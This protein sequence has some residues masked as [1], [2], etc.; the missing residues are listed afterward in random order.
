MQIIQTKKIEPIE[1]NSI[2]SDEFKI[3]R[4]RQNIHKGE[5][6]IPPFFVYINEYAWDAFIK[7]GNNVYD[8]TQ[9]EAQGILVGK[10]FKDTFGTFIVATTY[11]E[12]VGYSNSAFVSMTEECLIDIG[13]KCKESDDIMLIWVHTHPD[14]GVF[15]SGTDKTCLKNNF[16]KPYQIGIV[17][18]IIRKQHRGFKIINNEVED[19]GNYSLYNDNSDRL[20]KPYSLNSI[21]LTPINKIISNENDLTQKKNQNST[22][23]NE[24][25][26]NQTE[27]TEEKKETKKDDSNNDHINKSVSIILTNSLLI[28]TI[29][30][31]VLFIITMIFLLFYFNK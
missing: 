20:M 16:Y 9:F 30:V 2:S 21:S 25:T 13:K 4:D 23:H 22:I 5:H 15:Y 14:F 7:H 8:E 3:F 31:I 10:Y 28:L 11:F 17:A 27:E 19:F 6:N 1:L 24:Q 29:S 18:D 26:T 12:S